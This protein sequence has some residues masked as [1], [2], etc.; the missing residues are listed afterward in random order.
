MAY[1]MMLTAASLSL[2]GCSELPDLAVR[3]IRE[4]LP[5]R[6]IEEALKNKP[7]IYYQTSD[8]E[9]LRLDLKER[10]YLPE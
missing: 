2:S 8:G 10:N 7:I 4:E 1:L 3:R 5:R 9:Y 6:I